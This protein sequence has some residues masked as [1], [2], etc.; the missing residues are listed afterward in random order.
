MRVPWE[1]IIKVYRDQLDPTPLSTLEEYTQ[2]FLT[3]LGAR[4]DLFP[5]D[6]QEIYFGSEV[7]STYQALVDEVKEKVNESIAANGSVS[8]SEV[9]SIVSDVIFDMHG[10]F[11]AAPELPHLPRGYERRLLERYRHVVRSIKAEVF[12]QLPLTRESSR[13]LTTM[14]GRLFTRNMF[15]HSHSGIVIAGYGSDEI[16]PP[17]LDVIR[18]DGV[19]A[20]E[21][22]FKYSTNDP[23]SPETTLGMSSHLPNMM[24]CTR[25]W[26][27]WIPVIS[28]SLRMLSANFLSIT[29]RRFLMHRR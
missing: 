22:N 23:S 18:T 3:F 5:D 8:Q 13:R 2:S 19:V 28:A 24:W 14:A 25:S 27:V 12:Q 1:T 9:R 16:L 17:S 26:K 11:D 4:A 21:V 10:I 20:G 6:E 15:S 29:L 7:Y